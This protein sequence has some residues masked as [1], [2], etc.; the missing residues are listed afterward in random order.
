MNKIKM[1]SP[2]VLENKENDVDKEIGENLNKP[3]K[4]YD[5]ILRFKLTCQ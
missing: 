3:K 5:F 4:M 2:I 1:K